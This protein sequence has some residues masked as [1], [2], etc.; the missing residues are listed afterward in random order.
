GGRIPRRAPS[1]DPDGARKRCAALRRVGRRRQRLAL[2]LLRDVRLTATNVHMPARHR[3]ECGC[4]QRFPCAHAETRM[5]PRTMHAVSVEQ[6]FSKR[7]TVVR[8]NGADGEYI[9]ATT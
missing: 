4:V 7:S 6:S 3:I 9:V 1:D 2:D 5:V 8:A